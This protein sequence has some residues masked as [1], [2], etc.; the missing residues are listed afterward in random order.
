[1]LY[2]DHERRLVVAKSNKAGLGTKVRRKAYRQRGNCI[3]NNA[4]LNSM[5]FQKE[6]R[7]RN[8]FANGVNKLFA[9]PSFDKCDALLFLPST[10]ARHLNSADMPAASKLLHSHLAPSCEIFVAVLSE[11]SI[12]VSAYVKFNEMLAEMLPDQIMCVHS[13]KV[14]ENQIS[15]V[16]YMKGTACKSVFSSVASMSSYEQLDAPLKPFFGRDRE[17][18][19]K[20]AIK[21]DHPYLEEKT[22]LHAQAESELDLLLYVRINMVLTIDEVCKKVTRIDISNTLTDVKSLHA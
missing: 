11:K 6:I 21:R 12:S 18:T 20:L 9:F 16:V 5:Q 14:V 15:A 1:M 19:L 3:D 2:A 8:I 22:P 7:G 10:L 17:N 4:A 13:T